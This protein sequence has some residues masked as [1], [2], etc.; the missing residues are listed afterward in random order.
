VYGWNE[1]GGDLLILFLGFP[2]RVD[3]P[4]AILTPNPL[5]DL[6]QAPE[7]PRLAPPLFGGQGQWEHQA[8]QGVPRNTI[9]GAGRPEMNPML[10]REVVKGQWGPP[11]S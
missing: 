1:S 2:G 7:A 9:L 6:R 4:E 3:D 11:V 5:R 10:G 8:Q